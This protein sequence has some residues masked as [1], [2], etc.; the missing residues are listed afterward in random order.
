M[1]SESTVIAPPRGFPVVGMVGGGQLARMTQQA[2]ISLGI[3]FTVLAARSDDSAARVVRD[4][5]V[6]NP[7]DPEAL[8]AFG[9]LCDVVTFDHEQVPA[10]GL[11]ALTATDAAVRPGPGALAHAQDK[12]VMRQALSD[13]GVPCPA[14]L[15]WG[16]DT[17]VA[18]VT[19]QVG[20]PAV[21]KTSR[22]GYDG[23]GVWVVDGP[24]E[25]ADVLAQPLAPG[26]RW[27]IE[28]YVPFTAE[29]SAQV[30]RSPHGQP[31]PTRW[32]GRFK[33]TGSA[34]RWLPPPRTSTPTLR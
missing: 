11:A 29:L 10:P 33:P 30:A 27:L 14:W 20:W 9:R 12:I 1:T 22:G 19:A 34:K 31:S 13:M 18:H 32:S 24:D 3:G 17:T 26:A 23:R 15:E 21:V 25:L 4:V 5:V 6:G 8:A 2:A 16:P 7:D 28:Q